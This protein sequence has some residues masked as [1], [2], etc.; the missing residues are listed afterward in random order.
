MIIRSK[1]LNSTLIFFVVLFSFLQ[2][3]KADLIPPKISSVVLLSD[4]ILYSGKST[5]QASSQTSWISPI[6][7][8]TI[9]TSAKKATFSTQVGSSTEPVFYSIIWF[10]EKVLKEADGTTIKNPKIN[11]DKISFYIN[12]KSLQNLIWSSNPNQQII[13]TP[14]YTDKWVT[15]VVMVRDTNSASAIGLTK[16]IDDYSIIQFRVTSTPTPATFGKLSAIQKGSPDSSIVVAGD[17]NIPFAKYKFTAENEAFTVLKLDVVIDTNFDFADDPSDDGAGNNISKILLSYPK[18][19]GTIGTA[20][21]SMSSGKASFTNLEFYVA[22]DSSAIVTVLAD[23]NTVD[24]GATS[25]TSFR[26]GLNEQTTTATNAFEAQGE[27]SNEEKTVADLSSYT[28]STGVNAMVVR[29]TVPT[30]AKLFTTLTKLNNGLND[31]SAVTIAANAKGNIAL[32]KMTFW[33]NLGGDLNVTDLRLYRK[34]NYATEED[35]TNNISIVNSAGQDLKTGTK[36]AAQDAI[37]VTWNDQEFVTQGTMNIYILRASVA[38]VSANESISTYMDESDQSIFTA[39]ASGLLSS[40]YK[41]VWSDLSAN[42]HS[43]NSMDWTSGYLVP[44]FP[45]QVWSLSF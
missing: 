27:G 44:K 42:P 11:Y 33:F 10:T 26:L 36:L 6:P 39:N 19:D 35:I 30:V 14:Y 38:N 21:A 1:F 31:I 43:L 23:I 13:L 3:A 5:W 22:K 2:Y 28:N 24:L 37:Y 29:K 8:F 45:T 18:K 40:V 15:A 16:N 20:S 4:G 9:S 32:K 12:N 41:F 25:G 17:T 7:P 34:Q